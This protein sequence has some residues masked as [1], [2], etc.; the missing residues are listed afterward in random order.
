MTVIDCRISPDAGTGG[1]AHL[2]HT[3]ELYQM[4]ILCRQNPSVSRSAVYSHLWAVFC[5]FPITR[6]EGTF[7]DNLI[8]HP[9]P[10]QCT[11]IFAIP[12]SKSCRRSLRLASVNTLHSWNR[13]VHA[14]VRKLVDYTTGR[15]VMTFILSSLQLSCMCDYMHCQG[16]LAGPCLLSSSTD[17][18]AMS[19]SQSLKPRNNNS[20]SRPFS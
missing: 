8:P 10:E 14:L 20:I 1:W 5:S 19:W 13:A 2:A 7:T 4:D 16:T 18:W 6:A 15:F 12:W 11:M 3:L 17:P 9:S